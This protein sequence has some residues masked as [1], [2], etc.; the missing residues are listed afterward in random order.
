MSDFDGVEFFDNIEQ[1]ESKGPEVAPDGTYKA[2]I[3]GEEKYKAKSGNWTQ[4]IVFQI[5]GGKYRDHTEWYNLWSVNEDAKRISN[6]NFTFL[7]K[8]T[9]FKKFP[10]VGAEFVGK[11]L[12]LT[13]SQYEDKWINNEGVTV[14]S[15]KNKVRLY[16][17]ADNDGMS[18]PPE[19]VPPF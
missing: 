11:S 16:A 13:L 14:E 15:Y 10:N 17:P 8:A 7:T 6:E 12:T 1:T 19:A 3:V 4:K 2:K 9:G 5:D 18:P